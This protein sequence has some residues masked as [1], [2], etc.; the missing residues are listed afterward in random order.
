MQGHVKSR[1]QLGWV[2]GDKGNYD[3]TARH[4]TISAKMGDEDSVE[5]IKKMSMG[6]IASKAQYAEAGVERV[7]QNAVEGT[8]SQ[9]R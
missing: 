2:E 6:E 3:R 8:K 9:S 4:W 5:T 1:H 7:P